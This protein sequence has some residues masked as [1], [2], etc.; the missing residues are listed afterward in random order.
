M[1]PANLETLLQKVSTIA[2]GPH[3]DLLDKLID[4]MFEREL[5]AAAIQGEAKQQPC[6]Y[7]ARGARAFKKQAGQ[8]NEHRDRP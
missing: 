3:G 7:P 8:V 5:R 4:M 2:H 1:E 6:G